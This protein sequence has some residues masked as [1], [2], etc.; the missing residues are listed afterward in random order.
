[1]TEPSSTAGAVSLMALAVTLFGPQFGP[2]FVIVLGSIGGSFWAV[3]QTDT[4]TRIQSAMVFARA[5]V[6][7]VVLTALISKSVAGFFDG[8]TAPEIYGAVAFVIGALG[9]RWQDIFDAIKNRVATAITSS[10]G[11][12]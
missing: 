7:A 3:A 2:Y 10:G 9:N 1:M 4:A 11:S 6:T 5:I 8:V 12:K